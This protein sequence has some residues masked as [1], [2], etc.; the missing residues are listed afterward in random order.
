MAYIAYKESILLSMGIGEELTHVYLGEDIK[1]VSCLGNDT[2][3]YKVKVFDSIE[4]VK[5]D[6]FYT[7]DF[8]IMDIDEYKKVEN[9]FLNKLKGI[10]IHLD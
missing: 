8:T 5:K 10:K 9:V 2:C 1:Y 4:D 6:K 3:G 7:E